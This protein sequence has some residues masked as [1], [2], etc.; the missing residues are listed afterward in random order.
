MKKTL[1]VTLF[2]ISI[3][4]TIFSQDKTSL[5]GFWGIDW[6]TSK[7]K[8]KAALIEKGCT[9]GEEDST[10][11]MATGSFT[12]KEVVILVRFYKDQ[13][14]S[15]MVV[16]EYEK[17]RAIQTYE[18]LVSMLTEKY[19]KP[20]DTAMKFLSPYYLGD[21]FEEQAISVNKAI[22][23]SDWEFSD[24]NRIKCALGKG[25]RPAIIY[26]ENELD[27]LSEKVEK[28]KSKSDL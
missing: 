25:L 12:G 19:G 1:F 22:I 10:A 11:I 5:N 21:G 17:N 23:Y 6:K 8:V 14:F 20:T 2:L 3:G 18:S 15:A 16:Y 27:Q 28:E 26:V 24:N 13:L 9:I 4:F 7:E